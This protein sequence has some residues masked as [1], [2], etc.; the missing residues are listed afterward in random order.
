MRYLRNQLSER[1]ASTL[2]SLYQN[3]APSTSSESSTPTTS[4]D[5]PSKLRLV[6][7]DWVDAVCTGGS[8]WQTIEEIS[9]AVENGP[10]MVRSAGL[11]VESN[12]TFVALLDTII[13][14]GDAGGY[15][16][17]IP[18]GMVVRMKDYGVPH[19]E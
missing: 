4:L 5:D 15:V 3:E 9:E 19:A 2:K 17:V 18:R 8:E 13:L 14:D 10:S 16:H 7:I 12:D 6:V 11:L 1:S